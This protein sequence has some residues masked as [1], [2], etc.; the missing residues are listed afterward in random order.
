VRL[1]PR[2]P[3]VPPSPEPPACR[4]RGHPREIGHPRSAGNGSSRGRN[5]FGSRDFDIIGLQRLGPPRGSINTACTNESTVLTC[6][7]HQVFNDL[8]GA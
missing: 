4:K 2:K 5:L 1:A 8:G 3:M 6:D 7:E